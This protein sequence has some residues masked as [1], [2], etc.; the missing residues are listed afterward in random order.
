MNTDEKIKQAEELRK[1]YGIYDDEQKIFA[2]YS[3]IISKLQQTIAEIKDKVNELDDFLGDFKFKR[4]ITSWDG[5][6]WG[7]ALYL[8]Q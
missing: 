1:E 2:L 6:T 3:Q 4:I 7:D 8:K 5:R